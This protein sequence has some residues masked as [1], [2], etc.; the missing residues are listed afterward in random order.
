MK[1]FYAFTK[2][3]AIFYCYIDNHILRNYNEYNL[4]I[5]FKT[6]F[7]YKTAPKN[8]SGPFYILMNDYRR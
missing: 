6:I 4:W 3:H 7:A 5:V 2:I 1:N 8:N